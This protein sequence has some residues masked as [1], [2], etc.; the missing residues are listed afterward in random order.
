MAVQQ[1]SPL[2]GMACS[3]NDI[4]YRLTNEF[5]CQPHTVGG[6]LIASVI[7][8]RE[9]LDHINNALIDVMPHLDEIR[10]SYYADEQRH[11]EGMTEAEGTRPDQHIFYS[12]DQLD[13]F[14]KAVE[15]M[16]D[17]YV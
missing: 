2:Y 9:Q 7:G 1:D 15:D 3:L 13:D 4:E 16:R 17:A 14:I 5:S 6:E 12:L 10:A 8:L 11:F